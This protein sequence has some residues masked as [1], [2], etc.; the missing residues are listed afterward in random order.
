MQCEDA[1]CGHLL[2]DL[3]SGPKVVSPA[4]VHVEGVTMANDNVDP[5]G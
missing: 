1:V 4:A 2:I 5:E 3:R